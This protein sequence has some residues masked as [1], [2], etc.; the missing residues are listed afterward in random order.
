MC[1]AS[2]Q[3]EILKDSLI[4]IRETAQNSLS[5]NDTCNCS[6]PKNCNNYVHLALP[7]KELEDSIYD[8]VV[9]AIKHYEAI[10]Q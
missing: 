7:T 5:K 8:D 4:K 6:N 9:K 3:I 1:H 2:G 10:V